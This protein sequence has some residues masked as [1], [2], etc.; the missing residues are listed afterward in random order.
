MLLLYEFTASIK[1]DDTTT[2]IKEYF[3]C[4][5]DMYDSDKINTDISVTSGIIVKKSKL[6]IDSVINSNKLEPPF[7]FDI[8]EDDLANKTL[9]NNTYIFSKSTIIR[10]QSII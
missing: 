1:N 10:K 2:V 5:S 7:L 8:T 3:I 6:Y 4:D 9:K